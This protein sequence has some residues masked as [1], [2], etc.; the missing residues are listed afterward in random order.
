M[1]RLPSH[2]I[3][4]LPPP[5]PPFVF[6][7]TADWPKRG[8]KWEAHVWDKHGARKKGAPGISRKKGAQI[9]LG[10]FT[11]EVAAAR[12][13]DIASILI[14]GPE[15]FTNFPRDDYDEMKSLPPLNKKDLAFMLKDQ[16]IRAVPRYRGAVQYHPQDPW[17]AWIRKMCGNDCPLPAARGLPGWR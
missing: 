17:E 3:S 14:G 7:T 11:T 2:H 15:S 4:P 9:Y 12:A 10:V 8:E 16:R 5:G 1:Q 6:F 13:H